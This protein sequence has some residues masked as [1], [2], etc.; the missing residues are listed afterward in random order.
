M[1]VEKVVKNLTTIPY[2][3]GHNRQIFLSGQSHFSWFFSQREIPILVDPKQISVIFK[4][5]KQNKKTNK[6]TNK[7]KKKGPHLFLKLFLLSFPIFH[8]PFYNFPSFLLNFHPFSLFSLPLFSRYTSKNFPARSLWGA[9]CPPAP[10]PVTPLLINT[11]Y[12][13]YGNM[14]SV[15][16]KGTLSLLPLV[17]DLQTLEA[18]Q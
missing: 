6:K 17:S 8:L 4:T 7:Q 12:T 11:L 5:E 15:T 10:R 13:V 16:T 9:L 3:Q 18:N 14:W 2:Q 1:S